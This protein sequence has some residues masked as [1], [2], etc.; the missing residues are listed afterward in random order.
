MRVVHG[1]VTD[2]D[3]VQ[4]MSAASTR[5]GG[6]R[7]GET[8]AGVTRYGAGSVLG[9]H[10]Q[11]MPTGEQRMLGDELALVQDVPA[12]PHAHDLD[13]LA[14]EAPGH[15]IAV[16]IDRHEPV[17]GHNALAAHR[18]QEARLLAGAREHIGLASKALD[19][20]LVGGAVDAQVGDLGEP[21]GELLVEV[22]QIPEHPAGQEVALHVLDAGLDD[23][24]GLRPIGAA[25]PWLEPP[26][27]GEGLESRVPTRLALHR[28]GHYCTHAVVENLG[29]ASAEVLEG[30][31]VGREE[32]PRSRSPSRSAR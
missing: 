2:L 3:A 28:A 6:A 19:R 11:L 1:E 9:V 31:L 21:G 30:V 4:P 16:G 22:L 13:G 17:L 15:R 27:P 20:P 32:R 18:L 14:D 10:P 25:G 8:L 7:L 5:R 23:A 26:M 29:R 12:R 24:L